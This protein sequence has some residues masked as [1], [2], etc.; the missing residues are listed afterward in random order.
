VL[1]LAGKLVVTQR[2]RATASAAASTVTADVV[3]ALI[4][5]GWSERVARVAVDDAAAAAAEQGAPADM[6]RLLRV[7]LG[8]LGPQQPAGQAPAGQAAER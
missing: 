2:A 5:L 1:Q 3:M 4:G 6:A 7:A 8:M